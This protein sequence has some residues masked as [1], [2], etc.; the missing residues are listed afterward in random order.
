[1]LRTNPLFRR[2]W[3]LARVLL[4][5]TTTLVATVGTGSAFASSPP[6]VTLFAGPGGGGG[7]CAAPSQPCSLARA[8]AQATA[9]DNDNDDVVVMVGP[10]TYD[11]F[12]AA[13]A[14]GS[15]AS[16]TIEGAGAAVTKLQASFAGAFLFTGGAVTVS[17]LTIWGS[18]RSAVVARSSS[19]SPGTDVTLTDDYFSNDEGLDGG[20]VSA[21]VGSQVV[22][23]GDTFATDRALFGSGG[24]LFSQGSLVVS[25]DTFTGD[26]ATLY[27]G[28]IFA[29][30]PLTAA[31][32]T[33][34]DDSAA[35]GGAIATEPPPGAAA[36]W[37]TLTNDTFLGD[38]ASANLLDLGSGGAL[39]NLGSVVMATQDTF[40]GNGAAAG[41]GALL[42][43][44]GSVILSNSIL[45][46]QQGI[47]S[48]DGTA[49]DGGYNVES[50]DS[51]GLGPTDNPPSLVDVAD[52]GLFPSLAPN[53]ATGPET[54][55]ITRASPAFDEVPAS[56]C[57]V[58]SDER[59]WPRP[60]AGGTACDAGAF[61]YY[62]LTVAVS[63]SEAYMSPSASF[64]FSDDAP[65]GTTLEGTLTCS[66]VNGGSPLT[67][68]GFGDYTVDGPS[69]GGLSLGG[70]AA[71]SSGVVYRGVPGGF[72]VRP[73]TIGNDEKLASN[74][75]AYAGSAV[76]DPYVWGA[77]RSRAATSFDCSGLVVY[78]LLNLG[79]PS[80]P[81]D[82]YSQYAWA[83][84]LSVE[85]AYATPGAL[86]FGQF[87]EDG[88]PGPGHVGISLGNGTIIEAP[89]TGTSVSVVPVSLT[90][91]GIV[92]TGPPDIGDLFTSAGL[93]PGLDYDLGIGGNDIVGA[94]D[95]P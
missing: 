88:V 17:G 72:V 19:A 27:G 50:D 71:G 49:V 21:D 37:V 68:L 77:G 56:A 82:T 39:A 2:A 40:S 10:G 11:D 76:G 5:C 91:K 66:T 45:E 84:P 58:G 16:L 7:A 78:S 86:L 28:A 51:C 57:S 41:R 79:Y 31:D 4:V 92:T 9:P 85:A 65:A 61:E 8:L 62:Q 63:G 53:G 35:S 73:A 14:A 13:V 87:G 52:V 47:P 64:S 94:T 38:M 81:L 70:T 3:P 33:F 43:N 55:A 42:R 23:T 6:A 18:G 36:P 46:G 22:L 80:V 26:S 1:M 95:N 20:A 59:G 83:T 93:V 69:C 89:H 74:F 67:A 30:G 44:Q 12:S 75:I 54:L 34:S 25:Q 32:D 60:G 48:C 29:Q 24:A 15:L 90:A